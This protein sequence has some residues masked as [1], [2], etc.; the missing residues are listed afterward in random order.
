MGN[1][2]HVTEGVCLIDGLPFRMP[3]APY[4]AAEVT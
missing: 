3:L 2:V 1:S 4:N